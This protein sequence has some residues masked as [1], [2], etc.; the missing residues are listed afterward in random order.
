M[1]TTNTKRYSITA[2]ADMAAIRIEK[3][4]GRDH[5]VI[6]SY[7]LPFNVVMNR[8]LYPR[9]QIEAKFKTLEGT[10]APLGHPYG[11]DGKPLS[12]S[13]PIALHAHHIGAV[14]RNVRLDENSN[15]VYLEKWVDIDYAER[16]NGKEV[17]QRGRD[18]MAGKK[19]SPIHTSTG[20]ELVPVPVQ[21]QEAYDWIAN[22]HKFDHDAILLD[23][24]GAAGPDQGVGMFV[25]TADALPFDGKAGDLTKDDVSAIARIMA[26]F[27][28]N[29]KSMTSKFN[30]ESTTMT[31]EEIKA[32]ADQVA[33]AMSTKLDA[34]VKLITDA[35]AATG[36]TTDEKVEV[37]SNSLKT[38]M[39]ANEDAALAGK[40]ADVMKAFKMDEAAVKGL[41]VNALEAM[42]K[43]IGEAPHLQNN[44]G[45]GGGDKGPDFSKAPDL[46]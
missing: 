2:N 4:Q 29:P 42:H 38:V 9:D 7:T 25:N 30:Q 16:N 26:V 43:T 19:V 28:F 21:N 35:V 32:V 20:V 23:Q 5:M 6:P 13:D 12:A 39:Q 17:L 36:K 1:S 34:A 31:P 33:Q 37:V 22:I 18:A 3:Y 46:D 24:P 41:T 15:R 10:Y 45:G 40:R 14:N 11:E 27:G 44:H 8:G